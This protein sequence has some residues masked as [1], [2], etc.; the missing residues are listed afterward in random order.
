MRTLGDEFTLEIVR[1]KE[2]LLI[3]QEVNGGGNLCGFAIASIESLLRDSERVQKESDVSEM[4]T[5]FL[6]L[7]G[8]K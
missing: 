2:I 1:V 3:Y 4:A 6:Q 7:Q 5:L 8:V